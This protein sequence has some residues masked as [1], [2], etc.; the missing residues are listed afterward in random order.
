MPSSSNKITQF[1]QELKR[2]KVTKVIAM[3]AATAFIILEVVDIL[4][5]SLGLPA[6]T[7]NLVVVLLSVGF[8]ITVILS[9]IFDVTPEGIKKT[10][11][12]EE[13]LE[14]ESTPSPIKRRLKASDVIIAIL[15][16]AVVILLYPKI[17]KSDQFSKL[18]DEKGMISVAVLPFDNLTGDSSLYF[19][20]NGISE[21]LINGLGSSDELAVFSSQVISDV[22][23]GTRQV[24]TA[25][26]SPDLARRTASKINASIYITGNYIGAGDYITIMLNL[27]NT[28]NGE[29]IWSCIF[30]RN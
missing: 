18:R 3:Y 20:Q 2:R 7:L 9:W 4:A 30:Q 1:W 6:W 21:Y 5:P 10:E 16:V 14:Q 22:L 8:P 26:L 25:S 23:E 24:S 13:V 15:F 12:V 28:E 19:W 11:S 17:F 29:L 27:V